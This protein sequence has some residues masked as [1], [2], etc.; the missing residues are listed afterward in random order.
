MMIDSICDLV[1]SNYKLPHSYT[2][3][4]KLTGEDVADYLNRQLTSDV[5]GLTDNSIQMSTRLDRSGRIVSFFYIIRKDNQYFI[6]LNESLLEITKLELDKYLF[7]ED[8]KIEEIDEE[9][10]IV[11]GHNSDLGIHSTHAGIKCTFIIG[12]KINDLLQDLKSVS[13]SDYHKLVRLSAWPEFELTIKTGTI[14]NNTRLN[15]LAVSHSKGCYLGQE[16]VSKIETRR[17]ASSYPA[18][19]EVPESSDAIKFLDKYYKLVQLG[20]ED[21]VEGKNLSEGRVVNIPI[22]TLEDSNELSYRLYIKAIDLFHNNKISESLDLLDKIIKYTPDFADAYESKG[23]ILGQIGEFNKAIEAMDELLKVD[24]DSVMAHTNKSLYLMKI[25]KI[26]E[27]E[28]EKSLATV[29]SFKKLGDE[30]RV[31]K[32]AKQQEQ[33][34]LAELERKK[35]MF[36]QVLAI[37]SEDEL[38]NFGLG[39]YHYKVG[40]FIEAYNFLKKVIDINEKYSVAYS[41]L[42]K[43]CEKL[44]KIS[45]A[46]KIYEKGI[47]VASKNGDMMP[48]NEM[49]SN[50][51]DLLVNEVR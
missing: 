48:A 9:L 36:N 20:R 45:E 26:E 8:V 49:Q 23:A 15:E 7:S 35:E 24:E 33:E 41:M 14:V 29:A 21:R 12:N 37:D 51:N 16:T 5:I 39:Q 13:I 38:A 19:L 4:L 2:K 6:A 30:A 46:K 31:K 27:A 25:G 44:Q 10:S 47:S 3:L 50:L 40:N 34:E 43:T 28:E 17:G 22:K 1:L 18:L 42:G 11:T 32:E